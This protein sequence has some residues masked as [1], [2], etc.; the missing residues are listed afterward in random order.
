MIAEEIAGIIL[1]IS[2]G[3]FLGVI[4]GLIPGLHPNT[5]AMLLASL[6]LLSDF[7]PLY[8]AIII[9]SSSLANTFLDVIPSIFL[10][11]PDPE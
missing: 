2:F 5:F 10:G 3:V 1:S 6:V 7:P 8:A 9:L 4:S 11:A